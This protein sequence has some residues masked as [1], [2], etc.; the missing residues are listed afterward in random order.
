MVHNKFMFRIGLFS[1][2]LSETKIYIYLSPRS[3]LLKKGTRINCE[4]ILKVR[5]YCLHN[6]WYVVHC[7]HRT[8]VQLFWIYSVLDQKITDE[9]KTTEKRRFFQNPTTKQKHINCWSFVTKRTKYMNK[10]AI[11]II[12]FQQS[13]AHTYTVIV[14]KKGN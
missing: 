4:N 10:S 11:H 6:E 1:F 7:T 14:T 5:L 13:F 8:F 9:K 3:L 12:L 2:M